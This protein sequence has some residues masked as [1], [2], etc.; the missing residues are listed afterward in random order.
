MENHVNRL[1]LSTLAAALILPTWSGT[2]QASL[3]KIGSFTASG[4]NPA[5]GNAVSGTATFYVDPSAKNTLIIDLVNT[6]SFSSTHPGGGN[7]GGED[8]LAGLAFNISGSP[9][10]TTAVHNLSPSFTLTG[11]GTTSTELGSGSFANT[12]TNLITPGGNPNVTG[13]YG[14]ATTGFNGAFN[15]NGVGGPQNGIV[16]LNNTT[17]TV[18]GGLLP[19][20]MNGLEFTETFSTGTDLT[21]ATLSGVQLLFGTAG[22]GVLDANPVPEPSTLAIAGLCGLAFIG[23][24]LRRRRQKT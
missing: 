21:A 17:S 9:S 22:T 3:T 13:A 14:I 4:T 5:S 18:A 24:G 19:L 12:W 8:V 23:Y 11:N 10:I 2:S 7:L 20:A 1:F 6:S 15:G 16:G